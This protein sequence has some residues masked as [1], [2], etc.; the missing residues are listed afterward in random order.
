M[1]IYL[2]N[3]WVLF[4]LK[5]SGSH[6]SPFTRGVPTGINRMAVRGCVWAE[7]CQLVV[8]RGSWLR[9]VHFPPT[10]YILHVSIHIFFARPVHR[11][12]S[13]NEKC[14]LGNMGTLMENI[15][16]SGWAVPVSRQLLTAE[17]WAR[18]NAS[19]YGICGEQCGTGTGFT[20]STV[21]TT[22]PV[23]HTGISLS[24]HVAI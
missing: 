13:A 23:L 15:L 16:E 18:S 12:S 1:W 21:C 6:G 8:D 5:M 3:N 20:L 24:C 2:K 4:I 10:P 19:P 9:S 11:L 22:P 14:Y 7:G 17:T